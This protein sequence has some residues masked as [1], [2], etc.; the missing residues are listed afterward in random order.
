VRAWDSA[1]TTQPED[2]SK[3]WNLKGYLVNAWH[4]VRFTS[5]AT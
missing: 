1:A 2:A 3:L 5:V 4:R